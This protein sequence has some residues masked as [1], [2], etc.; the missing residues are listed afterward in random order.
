MIRLWS[1]DA[2]LAWP[3]SNCSSPSTRSPSRSLSQKAAPEPIPPS[4]TT[5]ASHSV[6]TLLTQRERPPLDQLDPAADLDHPV[7]L[8]AGRGSPSRRPGGS[9]AAAAAR[10]PASPPRG[11]SPRPRRSRSRSGSYRDRTSPAASSIQ[12]QTYWPGVPIGGCGNASTSAAEPSRTNRNAW[13]TQPGRRRS[14]SVPGRAGPGRR[15]PAAA[16]SRS[17]CR[18]RGAATPSRPKGGRRTAARGPGSGSGSRPSA[19]S[20]TKTV[21]E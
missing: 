10:R 20:S 8:R 11:R 1:W 6:R 19:R 21:S 4:P 2:P 18:S 3:S 5:I 13:L 15:R 12:A 17:G 16:T 9:S 7:G 14:T